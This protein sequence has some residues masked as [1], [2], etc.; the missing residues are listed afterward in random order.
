M[1][2]FAALG[3]CRITNGDKTVANFFLD[4]QDI[5][6][7][8]DHLDLAEIARIQE[9]DS[10]RPTANAR[11]RPRRCGRRGGQLPPHP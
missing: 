5:H 8:F 2:T 4:N 10:P 1:A 7:L 6:F 11:L 3:V 9:D